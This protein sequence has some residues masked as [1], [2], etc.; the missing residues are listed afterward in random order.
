MSIRLLTAGIYPTN[1][2]ES[3]ASSYRLDPQQP[4]YIPEREGV[5]SIECS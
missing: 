4:G 1:E 3:R 2:K 5:Q